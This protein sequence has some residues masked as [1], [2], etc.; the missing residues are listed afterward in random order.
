MQGSNI[1]LRSGLWLMASESCSI[2]I[3][4]TFL[5]IHLLVPVSFQTSRKNRE[6]TVTVI[7]THSDLSPQILHQDTFVLPA[8]SKSLS[9]VSL[10]DVGESLLM[11]GKPEEAIPYLARAAELMSN[12]PFAQGNFAIALHQVF[13]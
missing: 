1:E 3:I 8:A 9:L 11:Q 12:D 13:L 5:L 10:Y 4:A 7:S 2:K 6:R